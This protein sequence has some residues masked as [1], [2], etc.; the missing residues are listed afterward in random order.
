MN[1]WGDRVLRTFEDKT[2]VLYRFNASFRQK[3]DDGSGH[4]P[5]VVFIDPETGQPPTGLV[6][7]TGFK[8]IPW[9]LFAEFNS[10]P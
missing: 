2:P 6:P 8:T 4:N 10:L 9:Y 5:Q 7:G 3:D 1:P